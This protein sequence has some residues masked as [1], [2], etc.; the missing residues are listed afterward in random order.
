[1]NQDQIQEIL[2]APPYL[3]NAQQQLRFHIERPLLVQDNMR[4]CKHCKLYKQR[5]F[6]HCRYCKL[7]RYKLDSHQPFHGQCIEQSNHRYH[8]QFFLYISLTFIYYIMLIQQQKPSQLS[9]FMLVSYIYTFLINFT[10]FCYTFTVFN[11]IIFFS[12]QDI[13]FLEYNENKPR[14]PNNGIWK[15]LKKSFGDNVLL[16]LIP[17]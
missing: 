9:D 16:W 3:L 8:F 14:P 11:L 17:F 1:M 2:A 4:Y 15:N 13:S 10:L 7:C 6:Y 12:A 5:R